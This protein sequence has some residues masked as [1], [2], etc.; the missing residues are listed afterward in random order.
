VHRAPP[1]LHLAGV[2]H[3]V[4]ERA[5]IGG[6]ANEIHAARAPGTVKGDTVAAQRLHPGGKSRN[7]PRMTETSSGRCPA[8]ES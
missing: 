5:R 7:L 1:S 6:C 3:N 2:V 4:R 8:A